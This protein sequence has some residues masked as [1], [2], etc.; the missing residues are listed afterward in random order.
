MSSG[1]PDPHTSCRKHKSLSCR[2]S[3]IFVAR[4]SGNVT[5]LLLNLLLIRYALNETIL[6]A[7][8]TMVFSVEEISYPVVLYEERYE[9]RVSGEDALL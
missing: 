7:V 5:R 2:N 6:I 8:D 3:R 4:L 9:R 1:K